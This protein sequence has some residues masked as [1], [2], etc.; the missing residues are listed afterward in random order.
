MQKNRS[1]FY[2]QYFGL[3]S[4]KTY[5]LLS[6]ETRREEH[7]RV[8]MG[9]STRLFLMKMFARGA[10]EGGLFRERFEAIGLRIEVIG[11]VAHVVRPSNGHSLEK[12]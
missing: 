7:R 1:L 10:G 8:S 5:R 11:S 6:Q 4:V 2:S 12:E 3:L 9:E